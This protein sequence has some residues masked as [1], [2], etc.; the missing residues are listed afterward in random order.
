[1]ARKYIPHRGWVE[2]PD[3]R[4]V[5][6]AEAAKQR[7]ADRLSGL[8]ARRLVDWRKDFARKFPRFHG[9]LIFGMGTVGIRIASTKVVT[10]GDLEHVRSLAGLRDALDDI[11]EITEGFH[12]ACPADF[13]W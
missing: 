4:T 7:L 2:R 1:M 8:C 3:H 12:L 11:D 5:T 13:I 10:Y 6:L 9:S